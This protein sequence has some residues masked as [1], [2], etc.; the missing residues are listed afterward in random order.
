MD[1]M[2]NRDLSGVARRRSV[3]ARRLDRVNCRPQALNRGV[4]ADVIRGPRVSNGADRAVRL[5]TGKRIERRASVRFEP[6]AG[7]SG[8]TCPDRGERCR[9]GSRA[10][11]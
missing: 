1:M 11:F 7:S 10:Y 9:T 8:A 4:H 3:T 6:K 2:I 5:P